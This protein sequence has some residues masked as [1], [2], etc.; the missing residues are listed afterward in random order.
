MILSFKSGSEIAKLDMNRKKKKLIVT[1][2]KTNYLP[3]P[4]SWNKLF[5]PGKE[6]EQ[7]ILTDPLS[8]HDFREVIVAGMKKLG[9][10]LTKAK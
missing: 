6:K 5:D 1:S 10:E 3:T 8:D 7:E 9:Y 2:S 4:A